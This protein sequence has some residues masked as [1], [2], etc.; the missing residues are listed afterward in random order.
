MRKEYYSIETES[1]SRVYDNFTNVL[2][3][4]APIFRTT[5]SYVE[6][7]RLIINGSNPATKVQLLRKERSEWSITR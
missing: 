6:V 7:S 5:T 2:V 3:A 1:H 4:I